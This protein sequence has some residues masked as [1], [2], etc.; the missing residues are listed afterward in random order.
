MIDATDWLRVVAAAV[1]DDAGRVLLARRPAHLHQGG[2]WEFPGGK[3]EPGES[4]EQA[5]ARELQE[6]LG[7]LPRRS[8]PLIRIR[9]AYP[10]RRV[11]LD[12]WRVDAFSGEP[13]GR[14]GQPVEWVAPE[15]LPEREFPAANRPIVNAVRLPDRYLVTGEPAGD[16]RRFLDRLEQALVGGVRLVQLRAK[17]LPEAEYLRLAGQALE[18]C[19]GFG[20]RLLLNAPSGWVERVGADGVHLDGRRLARLERRP[21][22]A[23]YWVGA[24]CHDARE[25]ARAEAIGC[26]FA[27][28]SPVL[29]TAS[30]PGAA[31][32]G[33]EGFAE[34]ADAA[35][36][37][38]YALGGVGPADIPRAH[39]LYA[40]G[41]AA[42]RAL[43]EPAS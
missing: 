43:W 18:R 10:D 34:L 3:V 23:R 35:R 20:A 36:I 16:P 4:L 17:E 30:H 5:L 22:G 6:E 41:I 40:Q 26:D 9:H 2:L 21:L 38:V 8:R 12:V 32:L 11:E 25:L 27:V 42:I 31:A 29:P 33:W 14:E 24:S 15:E 39:G 13:H 19:R 7:I 28:L 37:P 1:F